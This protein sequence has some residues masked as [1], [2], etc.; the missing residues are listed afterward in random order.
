[1]LVGAFAST[2]SAIGS[3]DATVQMGLS[4]I[5]PPAF[6]LPM[7][8]IIS[9]F[10]GNGNG[11]LDGH[12]CGLCTDCLWFLKPLILLLVYA[13]GAVCGRCDV[14]CRPVNDFVYHHRSHHQLKTFSFEQSF[15]LMSGFAVPAALVTIAIYVFKHPSNRNH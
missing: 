1:M 10:I 6:V 5:S 8:F 4:A 11:H 3:V 9:A 15:V 14:W 2:T 12:H 13:I 7:L